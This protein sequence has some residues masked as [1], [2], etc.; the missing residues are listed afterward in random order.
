MFLKWHKQNCKWIFKRYSDKTAA[1]IV[2][3]CFFKSNIK[4]LYRIINDNTP[5]LWF[6]LNFGGKNTFLMYYQD[7]TTVQVYPKSEAVCS[8]ECQYTP[9]TLP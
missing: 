3:G 7:P 6:H 5:A 4:Q 2:P 9:T 1:F 8:S